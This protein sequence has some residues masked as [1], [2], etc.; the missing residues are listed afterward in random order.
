MS[1]PN[2][3]LGVGGG[4][5]PLGGGPSLQ[6]EEAAL[7]KGN[8][9]PLVLGLVAAL[10]VVIGIAAVLL[11]GDDTEQ[12]SVI[13]RQIN[14]MKQEHFDSFWGCALPN[15]P[16]ETLRTNQDLSAAITKRASRSP[17]RYGEHV[18]TKCL[19]KLTE[20]GPELRQLIPP[21]DLTTQLDAL[22]TAITELNDGWN[23]YLDQLDHSQEGYD[24][25]AAAPHISKIAKGWYDYRN[26]HGELNDTIRE[27][28][29]GAE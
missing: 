9:L 5:P 27:R 1:D 4:Q 15:Q 18:R 14:G 28:I 26:A 13:G 29:H 21:E 25:D 2:L 8:T 24:E 10:A 20:H 16:L 3:N 22:Q 19:V 6:D 12:Y 17:T 23:G 11:S 7:K